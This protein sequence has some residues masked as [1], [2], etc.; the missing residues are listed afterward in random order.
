[1]NETE[2][3]AGKCPFCGEEII[4]DLEHHQY[5]G[6]E[7]TTCPKCGKWLKIHLIA[8]FIVTANKEMQDYVDSQKVEVAHE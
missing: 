5:H 4:G 7:V 3:I 1:M 8:R 2:F 6:D